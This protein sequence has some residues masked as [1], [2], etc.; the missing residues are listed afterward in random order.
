MKT[1][2]MTE[3]TVGRSTLALAI[4][5]V[6]VAGEERLVNVHRVGDLFAE[7]MAGERHLDNRLSNT[8]S[9]VGQIVRRVSNM[10][11]TGCSIAILNENLGKNWSKWKMLVYLVIYSS[12]QRKI[13]RNLFSYPS[14]F[15]SRRNIPNT[16]TLH[17]IG[18]EREG[19]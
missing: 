6:I 19:R 10:I 2:D 12:I 16:C 15:R 1:S 13:S 7:T 9:L 8:L 4:I 17:N 11:P 14:S 3:H 5:T 18:Q